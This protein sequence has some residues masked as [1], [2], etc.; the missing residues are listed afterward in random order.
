MTNLPNLLRAASK[1]KYEYTN[2]EYID[3]YPEPEFEAQEETRRWFMAWTG[4][5][6]ADYSPFLVFGGD[7]TGGRA[8][9]W[10]VNC[11]KPIEDQPIVFFGSEGELGVVAANSRAY[12][13]LLA[14][15]IGPYEAIAYQ[16]LQ[17]PLH[18]PFAQLASDNGI[19]LS[20]DLWEVVRS[21]Q[22]AFPNFEAQ[23]RALCS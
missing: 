19:D 17:R 23:I 6:N 7:G 22:A 8:A 14:G 18:E 15:G 5:P 21:A 13:R 2:G 1:L 16:G 9:V 4:N 11:E 10:R 3:F 20:S 12:I